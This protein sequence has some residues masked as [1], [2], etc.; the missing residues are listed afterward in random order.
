[1]SGLRR[2]LLRTRHR[3]SSG[4]RWR[5]SVAWPTPSRSAAQNTSFLVSGGVAYTMTAGREGLDH[6]ANLGTSMFC[7]DRC[8]AFRR[9]T[10]PYFALSLWVLSAMVSTNV[11]HG[12]IFARNVADPSLPCPAASPHLYRQDFLLFGP[13]AARFSPEPFL[14]QHRR[15]FVL[16]AQPSPPLSASIYR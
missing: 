7:S 11:S 4:P 10:D 14:F 15:R 1:M 8:L 12:S 16:L 6:L 5:L 13:P 3:H 9:E 2:L